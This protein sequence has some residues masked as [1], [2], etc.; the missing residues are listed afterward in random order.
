MTRLKGLIITVTAGMLA[1]GMNLSTVEAAELTSANYGILSLEAATGT[2]ADEEEAEKEEEKEE[3]EEKK[4]LTGWNYNQAFGGYAYYKDNKPVRGWNTIGGKKY[5]FDTD[6]IVKE[7]FQTI[8]DKLYYLG[9][10]DAEAAKSG[11]DQPVETGFVV[12]DSKYFYI[13]EDLKVATG[14]VSVEGSE[15]IFGDKGAMLTGWQQIDGKWYYLGITPEDGGVN[16][17]CYVDNCWLGADGSWDNGIRI[18][19]A[20][21]T[22]MKMT[23][24]HTVSG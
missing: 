11:N 23:G 9:R 3:K 2:D 18:A 8:G 19:G 4:V 21:G 12:I 13:Y 17:N 15:Y 16:K 1:I 10:F 6:G 5:F 24:I 20:G 22:R 14:C 7:G